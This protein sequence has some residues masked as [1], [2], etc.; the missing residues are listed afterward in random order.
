MFNGTVFNGTKC[1]TE[2]SVQRNSVQREALI[3]VI[4]SDA[5]TNEALYF[6]L[7]HC[8]YKASPVLCYYSAGLGESQGLEGSSLE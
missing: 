5:L 1:S 4:G 7:P 2:Q 6:C 8:R 3:F